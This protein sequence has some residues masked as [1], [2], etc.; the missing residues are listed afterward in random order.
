MTLVLVG[1]S[2]SSGFG[3]DFLASD[4]SVIQAKHAKAAAQQV[5]SAVEDLSEFRNL[6][7]DGQNRLSCTFFTSPLCEFVDASLD[8]TLL[9]EPSLEESS[10]VGLWHAGAAYNPLPASRWLGL[11]DVRFGYL[12]PDDS[13]ITL[14]PEPDVDELYPGYSYYCAPLPTWLEPDDRERLQRFVGGIIAVLSLVLVR[15]LAALSRMVN[16][17]NL[18]LVMIAACLRYGHRQEPDDH[19]SLPARRYQSWPGRA[20]AV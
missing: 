18:V 14:A 2:Q 5:R 9:P 20:P 1:R 15:V 4:G 11:A 12:G 6:L 10:A 16:A 7:V 13:A 3:I 17:V 8:A 19:N